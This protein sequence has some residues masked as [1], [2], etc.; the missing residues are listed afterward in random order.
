MTSR[1][2]FPLQ[3][4]VEADGLITDSGHG[5]ELKRRDGRIGTNRFYLREAV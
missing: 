1:L 4:L 5:G 3:G 2:Y